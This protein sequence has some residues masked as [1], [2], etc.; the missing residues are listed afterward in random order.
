MIAIMIIV[1]WQS[2]LFS[3]RSRPSGRGW[4]REKEGGAPPASFSFL[5]PHPPSIFLL[6]HLFFGAAVE[7]TAQ[8]RPCRDTLRCTMP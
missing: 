8:M 3:C 2:L 7:A 5:L 6:F 1:I 4:R